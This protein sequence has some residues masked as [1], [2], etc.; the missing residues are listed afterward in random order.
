MKA[1]RQCPLALDRISTSCTQSPVFAL[2]RKMFHMQHT[3][4]ST[5]QGGSVQQIHFEPFSYKTEYSLMIDSESCQVYQIMSPYPRSNIFLFNEVTAGIA[6]PLDPFNRRYSGA[7]LD[8]CH[9]CS[10]RATRK[11]RHEDQ[12]A[13]DS[14]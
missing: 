14:L 12:R 11:K 6:K 2:Y 10:S 13:R 7:Q 1:L 9:R 5:T 3:A 4:I 8:G